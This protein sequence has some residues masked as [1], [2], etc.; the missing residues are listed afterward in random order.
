M[1]KKEFKDIFNLNFDA[2]RNYIYYRCGDADLATDVAQEAFMKIWEKQNIVDSNKVVALLYKISGDIFINNYRKQKTVLKFALSIKPQTNTQT[3][4]DILQF[5]EL[6]NTYNN[7]LNIMPEKQRVTFLM[8]RLEGYSYS[9][10]ADHL[11]L[12][13]KAIEKRMK[14]AI[15]FLRK[16][17][18]N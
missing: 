4:E 16:N 6:Q 8:H 3:P 17:I 5:K 15:E 18:N 12:S 11:N 13:V 10:I 1:T 7:I 9:E 14:L 2:V